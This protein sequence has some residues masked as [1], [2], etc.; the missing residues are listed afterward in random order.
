MGGKVSRSEHLIVNSTQAQRNADGWMRMRR[1]NK[2]YSWGLLF[3]VLIVIA[4]SYFVYC[5]AYN[6]KSIVGIDLPRL[7]LPSSMPD[8]MVFPDLQI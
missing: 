2:N 3:L 5:R 1:W 6:P 8:I 4:L 7:G